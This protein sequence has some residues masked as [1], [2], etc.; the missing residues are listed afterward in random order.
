MAE[1]KTKRTAGSVTEFIDSAVDEP[2]RQDC[3]TL[4]GMFETA[5]GAP[6]AMWGAAIVGFGERRQKYE[7]GRELD[8]FVAGFSPRKSDLTLYLP[9]GLDAQATS[10]AALGKHRTGKGCV[11]IKRLSD[12]DQA[13][14][15]GLIEASV[16][17]LK[18]T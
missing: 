8:W 15:R 16:A 11:Y 13:V 17:S 12:V 5:V 14:L 2:R 4:I 1:L 10:L 7:S 6:P 9:G 18:Q 3:R